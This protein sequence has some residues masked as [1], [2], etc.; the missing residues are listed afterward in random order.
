MTPGDCLF[1]F[2]TLTSQHRMRSA[3]LRI[4]LRCCISRRPT[5]FPLTSTTLITQLRTNMSSSPPA[6]PDEALLAEITS[7]GDTIRQLKL[8]NQ[9]FA[10]EVAKLKELK[11]KLPSAPEKPK[12]DQGGGKGGK[13]S[14]KKGLEAHGGKLQLKVPKV[15][16]EIVQ[17]LELL[18]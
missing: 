5:N 17:V 16:Q 2:S 15:S 11:G 10:E 8:S 4:P 13:G 3:L 9:P 1:L 14:K 7:L 12:V 6:Q 18:C